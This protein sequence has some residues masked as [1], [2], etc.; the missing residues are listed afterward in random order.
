[1]RRPMGTSY[2]SKEEYEKDKAVKRS[3]QIISH[4]SDDAYIAHYLE[5]SRRLF[6]WMSI[7]EAFNETPD[8][9][10]IAEVVKKHATD[11]A[12]QFLIGADYKSEFV[13]SDMEDY[14][15]IESSVSSEG[16][17]VMFAGMEQE[18]EY[19]ARFLTDMREGMQDFKRLS[20]SF[21]SM[22]EKFVQ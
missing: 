18:K 11:R 12:E 14:V 4:N 2:L 16:Y 17:D 8:G 20:D 6:A 21:L 5:S 1:M 10:W 19:A 9:F 15:K 7:A 22:R 3:Q 13:D